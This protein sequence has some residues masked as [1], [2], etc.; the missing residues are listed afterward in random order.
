MFNPDGDTKLVMMKGSALPRRRFFWKKRAVVESSSFTPYNETSF[1]TLP[2][3]A[4]GAETS[5]DLDC[6]RVRESHSRD[7]AERLMQG[8]RYTA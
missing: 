6:E 3:S 2:F 1:D 5:R 7:K 4:V 8:G